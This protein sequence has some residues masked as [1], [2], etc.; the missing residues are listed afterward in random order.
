MLAEQVPQLVLA[1]VYEVILVGAGGEVVAAEDGKEIEGMREIDGTGEA[2]ERERGRDGG[3]L[4]GFR[5]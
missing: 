5:T 3:G 1:A 2:R 4:R